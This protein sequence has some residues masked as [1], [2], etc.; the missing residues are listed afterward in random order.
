M[1]AQ[2]PIRAATPADEPAIAELTRQ[3]YASWVAEMGFAPMPVNADHGRFIRADLAWVAT[4]GDGSLAAVIEMEPDGDDW[5][6]FS[7]AVSPSLQGKGLGPAMLDFAERVG[8]ERGH[9]DIKLYTNQR[10]A[11][12]IDLYRHLGY[13]VTGKRPSPRR[14][15]DVIVDM[16]K[17]IGVERLKT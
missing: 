10:M 15:G 9:P 12:N 2:Y 8:A 4:D 1:D 7:V 17:P 6:V 16:A 13:A 11:R 14:P 5:T 3:A